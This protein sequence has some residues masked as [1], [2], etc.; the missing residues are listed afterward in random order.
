MFS[1]TLIDNQSDAR[2][3]SR[4]IKH[5][6]EHRSRRRFIF[7][8]SPFLFSLSFLSVWHCLMKRSRMILRNFFFFS[9]SS[10]SYSNWLFEIP[11]KNLLSMS[12][13][14][15][16][17]STHIKR[18]TRTKLQYFSSNRHQTQAGL[19]S[20][21]NRE[22]TVWGN[23]TTSLFF[24][25]DWFR[26]G[27]QY[28]FFFYQTTNIFLLFDSFQHLLFVSFFLGRLIL[29]FERNKNHFS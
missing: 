28:R 13:P 25:R 19:K 15:W 21:E 27:V 7:F 29:Q 2:A 24:R 22:T 20:K 12:I 14:S 1:S 16:L 26:L 18:R 9:S 3:H 6:A 23:K 11:P 4:S 10:S 8:I 5:H 17:A